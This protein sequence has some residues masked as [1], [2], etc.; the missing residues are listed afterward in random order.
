M[1]AHAAPVDALRWPDVAR[2]PRS[3]RLRTAVA[4]RIVRHALG[5]LPLYVRLGG[6]EAGPET[7]G[8]GG[9]RM[10][11]HDPAAFFRRVG[12]GGLIGF[13]E[14]YMAGEWD[15][16]DLVAVLTVLATHADR[17]IPQRLQR[18][19]KAF[20]RK[21]PAG[22]RNTPEGSRD[23]I[24]HHY[25]LSND[26]FALFLD[27]TMT[28][29]SAVFRA[30]PSDMSLLADAQRRK[31]DLLLDA[32][33]VGPGTRLLEVGTGWG[34]LAVRA[35]ARGARVHSVTL[36]AE[37]RDLARERVRAAGHADAVTIE[38]CDYRRVEGTYDAV[39][40]VEM[41]EAVGVEFWPEYFRTLDR[42]VVPG[43]RVVLQAITMAHDRVLATKDT[44]TWIQKY[45]FPGGMIPSLDAVES[46]TRDQTDLRSVRVDGYGAHYAE[47][48]R[49]WRETFTEQADAVDALGFDETFRRMWTFYLAYS[50]AG[51]RSGYLDV[52]QI[53]L[54]RTGGGAR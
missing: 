52:R 2:L 7:I 54:A 48:L 34:E 25:D 45:I 13:G 17:L 53:A 37:Q 20:V 46:I 16:P 6:H 23:N 3:S 50:E 47:T 5:G 36:S 38:L 33:D 51:F 40:S 27:E 32:A 22:Q 35:A 49:L 19:R 28:Y 24:H 15:A 29:S 18:L 1:A 8:L 43:G 26:L 12:V 14:S 42:L 39:V 10:N 41:I 31:I 4:E 44:H 30:L 21:Q 9:P 11:I